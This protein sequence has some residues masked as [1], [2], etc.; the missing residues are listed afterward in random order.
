MPLPQLTIGSTHH[1]R[2]HGRDPLFNPYLWRSL[3]LGLHAR[4]SAQRPLLRLDHWL[5]Q[6]HPLHQIHLQS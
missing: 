1:R 6:S 2:V 5:V 3:L 4:S